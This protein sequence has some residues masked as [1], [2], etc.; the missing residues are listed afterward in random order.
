MEW[1]LHLHARESPPTKG[2]VREGLRYVA[3]LPPF[4]LRVLSSCSLR[5]FPTVEGRY[6]RGQI[7]FRNNRALGHINGGQW[8]RCLPRAAGNCIFG[9]G[10]AALLHSTSAGRKWRTAGILH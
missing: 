9:H 5:R 4:R 10:S 6:C 8:S 7:A 2:D 3:L 1:F